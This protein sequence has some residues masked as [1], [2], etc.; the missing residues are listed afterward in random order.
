MAEKHPENVYPVKDEPCFELNTKNVAVLRDTSHAWSQAPIA[1]WERSFIMLT[2]SY[3]E[4]EKDRKNYGEMG[5]KRSP[6]LWSLV[7]ASC[8]WKN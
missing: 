5:K 4:G 8:Q 6:S 1:R 2:Q 7:E 3:E